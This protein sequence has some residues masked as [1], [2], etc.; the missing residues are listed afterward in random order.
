MGVWQLRVLADI[1]RRNLERKVDFNGAKTT[2][3][4]ETTPI[5]PASTAGKRKPRFSG[6]LMGAFRRSREGG[7]SRAVFRVGQREATTPRSP[8]GRVELRDRASRLK[9]DNSELHEQVK[10]RGNNTPASTGATGRSQ[11]FSALH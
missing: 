11:H 3:R 8:Q 5:F 4:P 10:D 9:R 6:G 7:L 1:S 2:E